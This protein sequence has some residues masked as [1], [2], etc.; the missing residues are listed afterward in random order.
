MH[1]YYTDIYCCGFKRTTRTLRWFSLPARC[2][3][4]VSCGSAPSSSSVSPHWGTCRSWAPGWF[5]SSY[6][7]GNWNPAFL[8]RHSDREDRDVKKRSGLKMIVRVFFIVQPPTATPLHL[9]RLYGVASLPNVHV[10]RGRKCVHVTLPPGTLY[11][12]PPLV[13]PSLKLESSSFLRQGGRCGSDM[14]GL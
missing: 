1:L 2:S 12:A 8:Q 3:W 7:W 6:C 4:P 13:M 5:Q 14:T 11:Q 10:V 9:Y